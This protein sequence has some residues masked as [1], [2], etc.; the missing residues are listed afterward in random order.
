V[1]LFYLIQPLNKKPAH[2]VRTIINIQV[3]SLIVKFRCMWSLIYLFLRL[4]LVNPFVFVLVSVPGLCALSISNDNCYLA[5]PG[6][7][8]IGEVQVFDTVNLVGVAPSASSIKAPLIAC[9]VQT[10]HFTQTQ[11]ACI[12]EL[13]FLINL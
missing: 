5:Y 3:V 12:A 6:S 4:P 7:A 9:P 8:T 1:I 10:T 13:L 11:V 2:A